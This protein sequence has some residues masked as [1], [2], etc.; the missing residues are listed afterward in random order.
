MGQV[1]KYLIFTIIALPL[2]ICILIYTTIE[3]L[4]EKSKIKTK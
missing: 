3:I 4:I 1:I 2:L